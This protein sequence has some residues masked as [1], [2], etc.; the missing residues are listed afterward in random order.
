MFGKFKRGIVTGDSMSLN[1]V[2]LA[3]L[4]AIGWITS[5][6]LLDIVGAVT[7]LVSV[8]LAARENI[9]TYPVGLVNIVAFFIEFYAVKLY[10][11]ATLQVV[12]FVLTVIGW[13]IW[14]TKRQGYKVR[15]TRNAR[16][17]ELFVAMP[18][19][20]IGTVVWGQYLSTL[21]DPAPLL[22]ALVAILSI[23][24]Q[25]FLSYKVLQNWHFWISVDVLSIGLYL[26]KNLVVTAGVYA[27]FLIIATGGLFAWKR[28][29]ARV[30]SS[31]AA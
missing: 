6:S 5:A 11:D 16:R 29:M 1:A 15:P 10:A 23:I 21:G 2:I 3:G 17:T 12:F 28:E 30:R 26:Y 18:I 9:W 27:I 7:G 25:Y 31:S 13:V 24:A 19:V 8:W 4:V 20:A 14:L 22:D